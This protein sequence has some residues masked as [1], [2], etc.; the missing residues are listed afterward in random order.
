[1]SDIPEGFRRLHLPT[2]PF[3]EMCGPLYGRITD[4]GQFVMGLLVQKQHCNP[5]GMCH[6]GMMMT[7]AD[8]TML[9]G[10]NVQTGLNRY[11]LTVNLT[12]DFLAPAPLGSW[13]EG[14]VQVLRRTRNLVFSQG[15][16]SVPEGPAARISGIFKP[17]GD[18][19]DRFRPDRFFAN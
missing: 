11:L 15:V 3:I 7:L 10:T 17:V 8:M 13:I 12:T 16:L 14:R 9:L 2:N 19:L 6:G 5:G 4:D 1:M 18:E